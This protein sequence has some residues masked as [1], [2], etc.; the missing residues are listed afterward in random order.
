ML[1][2][3]FQYYEIYPIEIDMLDVLQTFFYSTTNENIMSIS[4]HFRIFTKIS[5]HNSSFF[6]ICTSSFIRIEEEK[7]NS[8]N[9]VF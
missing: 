8:M 5:Y 1:I 4:V 3:N 2:S 7:E 6:E 9:K